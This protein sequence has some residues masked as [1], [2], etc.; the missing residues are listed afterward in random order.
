MQMAEFEKKARA[1]AMGHH[2]ASRTKTGTKASPSGKRP[3]GGKN[4]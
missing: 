3:K 1:R 4:V 2:T